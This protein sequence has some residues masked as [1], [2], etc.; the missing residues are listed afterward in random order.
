M[1]GPPERLCLCPAVWCGFA[2]TAARLAAYARK[3]RGPAGGGRKIVLIFY[4]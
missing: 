2:T 4:R 1:G 3:A